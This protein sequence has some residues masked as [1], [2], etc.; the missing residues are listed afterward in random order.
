MG[1][2]KKV[3][4]ATHG[5]MAQGIVSSLS[6]IIGDVKDITALNCY[7][8]ADF[9]LHKTILPIVSGIDY[10]EEDLIVC[11]DIFGGSVN[12]G[13]MEYLNQ[14]PYSLV[15]NVN[16]AFLVDLMLNLNILDEEGIREKAQGE[17]VNV[18]YIGRS[19]AEEAQDDI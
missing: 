6:F 11:T 16:L 3:V 2:K 8:D 1:K 14:Y 10:E 5:N 7:M 17:F 4:I 12:N 13:F 9:D 18:K 19:A 15:T